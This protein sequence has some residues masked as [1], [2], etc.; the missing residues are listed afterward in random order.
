MVH[1]VGGN[2][3]E[4][5]WIPTNSERLRPPQVERKRKSESNLKQIKPDSFQKQDVADNIPM[6][7]AEQ[8]P[9]RRSRML[10]DD[11]RLAMLLQQE[12]AKVAR[13]L[14]SMPQKRRSRMLEEEPTQ[15]SS[16]A[17]VAQPKGAELT[18]TKALNEVSRQS[19]RAAKA[20][21]IRKTQVYIQDVSAE[22]HEPYSGASAEKA[23]TSEKAPKSAKSI[24][25]VK[26]SSLG[27]QEKTGMV[28]FHI[29]ADEK[30]TGAICGLKKRKLCLNEDEPVSFVARLIVDEVTPNVSPSK[31]VIR[32][33]CGMLVGH[34]HSMRYV[35]S[36]LWPRSK[37]DLVLKCSLRHESLL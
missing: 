11:A 13:S 2:E 29:V 4:V 33:Q 32:T 3:D 25:T 6:D 19:G 35:R 10:S 17:S 31:I 24:K 26:S 1:Y 14:H 9:M 22:K 20:H 8:R 36:V 5:E 12:E 37:G 27:T 18:S 15:P 34:E 7:I 21:R 16:G 28:A 30:S 23:P